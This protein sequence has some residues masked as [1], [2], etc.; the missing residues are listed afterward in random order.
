VLKVWHSKISNKR[1]H[2]KNPDYSTTYSTMTNSLCQIVTEGNHINTVNDLLLCTWSKNRKKRLE[3]KKMKSNDHSTDDLK[4]IERRNRLL[5]SLPTS[6]TVSQYH[7]WRPL[8]LKLYLSNQRTQMEA[9]KKSILDDWM[10]GKVCFINRNGSFPIVSRLK[11]LMSLFPSLFPSLSFT[12]YK[13]FSLYS[14]KQQNRAYSR[15]CQQRY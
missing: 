15:M 11:N 5:V 13:M 4:Y 7:G 3:I 6:D 9:C 2:I 8:P 1:L 10:E 14:V 12:F